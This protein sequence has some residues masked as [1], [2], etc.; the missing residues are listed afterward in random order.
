MK[1]P[2]VDNPPPSSVEVKNE[3]IYTSTPFCVFM[4]GKVTALNYPLNELNLTSN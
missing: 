1:G 3:K 4:A 2:E